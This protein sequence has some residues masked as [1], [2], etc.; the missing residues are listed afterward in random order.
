MAPGGSEE[1]KVLGLGVSEW[2]GAS[3]T[4]A[5]ARITAACE[6]EATLGCQPLFHLDCSPLLLHV[7]PDHVILSLT[8]PHVYLLDIPTSVVPPAIVRARRNAAHLS[9]VLCR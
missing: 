9:P 7:T 3:Q 4:L 1:G 5:R 8:S 6:Q 2:R